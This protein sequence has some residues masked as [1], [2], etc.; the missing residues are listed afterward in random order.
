MKLKNTLAATIAASMLGVACCG[1]LVACGNKTPEPTPDPTPGP[2]PEPGVYAVTFDGNGGIFAESATTTTINTTDGKLSA[3]PADPTRADYTF[4]GWNF[5][6]DGSGDAVT[7]ETTY[8][9]NAIVYA[10]WKAEVPS[11]IVYSVTFDANGGT[12]A[13]GTLAKLTNNGKLTILPDDPTPPSAKHRFIGWYTAKTGGEKVTTDYTFTGEETSVTVYARY[14][15][16]FEISFNVN[17][18][19]A[20]AEASRLTTD[21][22]LGKLPRITHP[23]HYKFLGWFTA[24]TGGTEVTATTVF[25]ADGT[26]YAH[27][28][29]EEIEFVITL[30]AN[31]GELADGVDT[32]VAGSDGKLAA[33]PEDP[34]WD[35]FHHF[36]GWFTESTGGT[37]IDINHVFDDDV[38]IHAQWTEDDIELDKTTVELYIGHL[39]DVIG[40]V[41]TEDSLMWSSSD[42][43]VVSVKDGEITAKKAGTA[44][45]TAFRSL[46]GKTAT[47][48]VTVREEYYII[49]NIKDSELPSWS[50]DIAS[51]LPE[52]TFTKTSA[53]V[54]TLSDV[55][56]KA[57]SA[58]KIGFTSAGG[59]WEPINASKNT[60][61]F[62]T[63]CQNCAKIDTSDN[64]NILIQT[65]GVYTLTITVN[66]A[67]SKTVK[68]NKTGEI[69]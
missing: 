13:A 23:N 32:L 35:Q 63:N 47:C 52:F 22:K 51:A 55:A 65:S 18:G 26:V 31:G 49:G 48:T 59:A 15:E 24:A 42:S 29:N 16:E 6:K 25:S 34:T 27:F 53:N 54:Y 17:G 1:S 10:Q 4:C 67:T 11:E 50:V 12:L 21:G 38:T 7:V 44:T 40:T 56:L 69:A 33:M 5:K 20:L 61:A 66:S 3:L 37:Q 45:I 19:N 8:S 28:D 57:G 68:F 46:G 39:T 36:S 14:Q 43:S 62:E 2:T 9:A 30:D 64:D 60:L 58:F 41:E